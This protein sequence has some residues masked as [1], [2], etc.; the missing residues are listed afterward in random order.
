MLANP[1]SGTESIEQFGGSDSSGPDRYTMSLIDEPPT[2]SEYF[3]EPV[4]RSKGKQKVTKGNTH[5]LISLQ[6]EAAMPKK[7][8][9]DHDVMMGA[10]DTVTEDLDNVA[11][12]RKRTLSKSV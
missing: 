3:E 6:R 10:I 11:N 5:A 7:G 9:K 8:I 12:K 1:E 2:D 4:K